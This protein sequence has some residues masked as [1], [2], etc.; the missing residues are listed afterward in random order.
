MCA[1]PGNLHYHEAGHAVLAHVL[2]AGVSSVHVNIASNDGITEFCQEPAT[3]HDAILIRMAGEVAESIFC[4]TDDESAVCRAAADRGVISMLL[5]QECDW[6][7]ATY[8]TPPSEVA[9]QIEELS[10]LCEGDTQ[11]LLQA[12]S[13]RVHA[14][15]SALAE[16]GQLNHAGFLAAVGDG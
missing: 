1:T 12:N 15:A 16:T 3:V 10:A 7:T 8:G 9:N 6:D 4:S 5:A 14:V 2:G 11:R 13:T